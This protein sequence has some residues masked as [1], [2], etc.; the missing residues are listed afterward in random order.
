VRNQP[1]TFEPTQK[2]ASLREFR[3]WALRIPVITYKRCEFTSLTKFLGALDE[4]HR[5]FLAFVV[6][7]DLFDRIE[8]LPHPASSAGTKRPDSLEAY[9]LCLI[10]T[11][12]GV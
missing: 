11:G 4:T 10:E 3:H 7:P 12:F 5:S 2:S 1:R 8:V 6:H 9:H